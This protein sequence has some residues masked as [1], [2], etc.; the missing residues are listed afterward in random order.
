MNEFDYDL[1]VIGAGSGGVRAA[2]MAATYGAKVAVAEEYRVGGT[3]VIR[4]CV[5]KKLMVYASKFAHDF[6]DAAG[7]GWTVGDSSF[8]WSDFIARKDA[9]IDRLNG[10]YIKNLER[11]N[12]E[13]IQSRAEIESPHRVRLT[14]Q[15]RHV[16]AKYILVATGGRPNFAQHLP[17]AEHMITS[18]EVFHLEDKPDRV[19][20]VGGGYIA[21]EFA[22]IF[23]GLG[24]DTTVLY[25]GEEILRGFDDDVRATLHEEMEK[26]G[27]QIICNDV[28]SSIEK[29]ED[30]LIVKTKGGETLMADQILSAIGRSPYTEGLGLERVGVELDAK[31]A[32]KVDEHNRTNIDHVFAVGDV[33]NRVNLTP[34]AIREGAALVE[35]LFNN[36][37]TVIDYENIPTAVFTQ[38]EIGTVGM[39]QAE[40]EA[41]FD[42]LDIYMAK[43]RPMK[44]TLAG[45]DE[46]MLMKIIVDADSDK[47]IGCHVL[48]SDS[49]EMAQLLGIAV[50]MG[51]TKA[52]FDATMAVHP[53]ASEELVTM[54]EPTSRIRKN[55]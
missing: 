5:P 25:R 12:V 9:E 46:K 54:K 22:G 30:G 7:F 6:E 33:T 51:A 19:V 29:G 40:A 20:V 17:G 8:S 48:G 34:V 49:G 3:C 27:V 18:N 28:I 35:T 15:D 14:G 39:S 13:I 45:N 50:K 1:F 47:V 32:I 24:V 31:G 43:F 2:R 41:A 55:G 52:D 38:P 42:N 44:N 4:G 36:N 37:P 10:L 23:N 11:H 26:K 21:L 53:T 16:T